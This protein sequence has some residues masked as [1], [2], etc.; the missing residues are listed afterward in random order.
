MKTI[1]LIHPVG[2][3]DP[4]AEVRQGTAEPRDA[5]L[6]LRLFELNASFLMVEHGDVEKDPALLAHVLW[7]LQPTRGG[8][9]AKCLLMVLKLVQILVKKVLGSGKATDDQVR[10]LA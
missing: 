6:T 10:L 8:D 4:P 3:L 2:A 5:P 7:T 1:F 9:E